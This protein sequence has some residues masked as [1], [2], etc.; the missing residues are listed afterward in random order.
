MDSRPDVH[1]LYEW[2]YGG[3]KGNRAYL[4][5][6]MVGVYYTTKYIFDLKESDVYWCTADPGG[7][8]GTPM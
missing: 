6:Y 5:G 3:P 8:P 1:P 7:S 4:R 2:D